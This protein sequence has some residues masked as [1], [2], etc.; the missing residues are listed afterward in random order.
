MSSMIMYD[1]QEKLAYC[2]TQYPV[3]LISGLGFT[4]HHFLLNY[5]GNIPDFLKE[6][7]CDV[8]TASQDAFSSHVDNAIKLKFRI[9]DILEK[10]KKDKINIIG[11][12]KGGLEARYMTS[13]LAMDDVVA[14]LTTLGSPH[15]GSGLADLVLG[16]TPIGRV[17]GSRVVNLVAR[18]MGD[19]NPDSLRAAFQVSKKS[20]LRFN[21]EV[22]DSSRVH[23]QSWA[24]HIRKE[25]PNTLWRTLAG[26]LYT[27]DGKNDG[28]VSVSSA[29][30]GNYR[31]L[32]GTEE[33]PSISHADMVGLTQFTRYHNFKAREFIADIVHELKEMGY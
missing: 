14:S 12:S 17:A 15:Y 4:E 5:W 23:Y 9:L 22:P 3:I 13:R 18:I 25:Y 31:G 20:M 8:Y 27:T 19:K 26:I 32:I 11:H 6:R 29:Q 1:A 28:L 10:T 21:D 7:G 24:G 33:A 30:W 2:H 16:T